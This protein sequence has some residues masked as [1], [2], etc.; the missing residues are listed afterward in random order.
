[1]KKE[2]NSPSPVK[3]EEIGEKFAG[4]ILKARA[5]RRAKVIS[6]EGELGSGKTTFLKGV[7]KGLGIKEMIKSPTFVIMK[8]YKIGTGRRQQA[9]RYFYHIDC[10]RIERPKEILGLGWEEILGRPQDIIAVEWG[11]KIRKILPRDYLKIVFK[12]I[13]KNTRKL[14][15]KFHG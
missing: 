11:E 10:Y 5:W 12:F 15:L 1:M 14:T 13:N 9:T 3:T 4:A 6:L 2:V 8:K 7:A